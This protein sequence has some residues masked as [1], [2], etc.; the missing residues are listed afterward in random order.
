MQHGAT[1]AALPHDRSPRPL[2]VAH[3]GAWGEAPQNSL[4]AVQR[5]IGLGCDGIEIDVRRTGDGRIV[6]VH[7]ARLRL[8][9]V[10]RLEHRQVQARLRVGQAPLLEDVLTLAAGRV[11]VDVEL[12]EDGYVPAVMATV[13][14]LLAADQYVVTSFRERILEQVRRH[15][16]E[17]RIGLLVGRRR[18]PERLARRVQTA[19]ADFLA[20]HAGLARSGI[21][22]WAAERGL[23]VWTWTVNEP[24]ALL[25]YGADPRVEALITDEPAR[26]LRLLHVID[27]ADS[28]E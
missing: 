9:T 16:P 22:T 14:R 6:L 10:G 17:A 3:R 20:V 5:A 27:T 4:E 11:K 15:A 26:A 25:T 19:H 24:Q 7:D 18:T 13:T 1:L 28:R 23:P 12:K 21:V 2:I 8:R